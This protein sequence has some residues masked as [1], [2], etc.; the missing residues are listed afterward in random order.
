M[1][2]YKKIFYLKNIKHNINKKVRFLFTD[3]CS[4]Y[5]HFVSCGLGCQWLQLKKCSAQINQWNNE[6]RFT[7]SQKYSTSYFICSR[8]FASS[9]IVF[10]DVCVESSSLEFNV[11]FFNL[12]NDSSVLQ[13]DINTSRTRDKYLPTL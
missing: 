11:L 3:F 10:D 9:V 6:I 5:G 4:K 12:L 1:E 2:I 7:L 8:I 13:T